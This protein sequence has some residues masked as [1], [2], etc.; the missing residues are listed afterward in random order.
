[1]IRIDEVSTARQR[2]LIAVAVALPIATGA[3]LSRPKNQLTVYLAMQRA[4]RQ[5]WGHVETQGWVYT[6]LD[7]RFYGDVSQ[8]SDMQFGDTA[9]FVV[10]P[11]LV[12]LRGNMPTWECGQSTS[13]S[14]S[15]ARRGSGEP[16]ARA[17]PPA[18]D[19]HG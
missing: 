18:C 11:R 16:I 17:F 14:I 7:P 15:T 1:M 6:L 5:H 19:H 4:A 9:R 10:R 13:M 2:V 3:L 8:V 12:I